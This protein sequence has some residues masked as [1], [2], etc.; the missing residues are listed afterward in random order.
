[1]EK[2]RGRE[3]QNQEQHLDQRDHPQDLLSLLKAQG[4]TSQTNKYCVLEGGYLLKC[5]A[6]LMYIL[7]P[8]NLSEQYRMGMIGMRARKGQ[9]GTR[10]MLV[11]G[12]IPKGPGTPNGHD[13]YKGDSQYY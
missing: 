5:I 2:E 13:R 9:K 10:M 8:E 11:E 6:S 7:P 1:M 4:N 12:E 3:H